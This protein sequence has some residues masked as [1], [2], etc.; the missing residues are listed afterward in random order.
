MQ[1]RLAATLRSLAICGLY[2]LLVLAVLLSWI[3]GQP[4][5]AALWFAGWAAD[6]IRKL[7]A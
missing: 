5:A 3:F 6:T 2:A 7:E 1:R 4:R